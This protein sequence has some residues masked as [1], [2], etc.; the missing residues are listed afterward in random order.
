VSTPHLFHHHDHHRWSRWRFLQASGLLVG[1]VATGFPWRGGSVL[2]APSGSGI[3]SRLP[4][5]WPVLQDAFGI[6]IPAFVPIEVDP[7]AGAFDRVANPTMIWDFNGSFGLIEATGVSDPDHNSDGVARRWH[8]DVRF[9]RGMFRDRAG[10]TQYG[11]FGF[12]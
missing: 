7:F 11:A 5:F 8:C 2:A 3:P 4:D 12:S 9:M 6:E 10:R 1:A